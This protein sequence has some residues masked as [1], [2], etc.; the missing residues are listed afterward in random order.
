MA[1]IRK[2]CKRRI[3]WVKF[4]PVLRITLDS[5]PG[6]SEANHGLR[7]AH[8]PYPILRPEK[9]TR[10]VGNAALPSW[11]NLYRLL[12]KDVT[13]TAVIPKFLTECDEYG[14]ARLRQGACIN[15]ADWM[16]GIDPGVVEEDKAVACRIVKE[17][18]PKDG[19]MR[20]RMT[21]FIDYGNNPVKLHDP[22]K[23]T[24]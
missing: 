12:R 4:V 10:R 21:E 17:R 8:L 20:Y 18:D 15:E 1:S 16:I 19:V 24:S 9:H 3:A 7:F 5:Y 6:G 13:Q 11:D 2:R 22:A 14:L 23:G